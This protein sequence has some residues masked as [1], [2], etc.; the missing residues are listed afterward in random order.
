MENTVPAIY[1]GGLLRPLIPLSL[2]DGAQVELRIE[3]KTVVDS[4]QQDR[5]AKQR[6]AIEKILRDAKELPLEG[7]DDGFSGSDHDSILYGRP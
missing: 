1:E 6:R 5:L 4:E 2:P 3:T 7:I